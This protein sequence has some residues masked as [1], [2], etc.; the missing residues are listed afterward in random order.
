MAEESITTK[1]QGIDIAYDESENQWVFELR[2][3]ERKSAS[4]GLAKAAIDAPPP[5]DKK[6]FKRIEVYVGTDLD[7]ATVTS[8]AENRYGSRPEVWVNYAEPKRWRKREKR[9][10]DSCYPVNEHNRAVIN[11]I[12]A[13][14]DKAGELQREAYKLRETLQ[15]LVIK[16]DN[17]E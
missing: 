6:P 11:Q 5:K 9:G 2:G 17:H 14:H 3:K 15:P 13:L 8:I 1:Y 12:T 4:L 7:K 16:P 10:V